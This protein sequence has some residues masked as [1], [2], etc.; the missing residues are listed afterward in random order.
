MNNW[1]WDNPCAFGNEADHCNL[2][3]TSSGKVKRT[4]QRFS[5]YGSDGLSPTIEPCSCWQYKP[6][7][8]LA[9]RQLNWD[10]IIDE[11]DDDENWAD[12]GVP[13]SGRSRPGDGN[14]NDNGEGEEDT[15]G[16]AKG[17]GKGREQRTGTGNGRGRGREMVKGKVLLNQPQGEMISL[18]PLLCSCSRKG[19]RHTWTQRAN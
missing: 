4:G 17:T 3:T 14:D 1:R 15:Q 6:G 8:F 12:P 16:G 19:M 5:W 13:S 18:V 7:D 2:Q 10:E 11:D 9:I